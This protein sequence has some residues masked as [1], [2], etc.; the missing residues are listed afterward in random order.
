MTFF[1]PAVCQV[2]Y[3]KAPYNLHYYQHWI[4]L[5]W[6]TIFMVIYTAG[7]TFSVQEIC[8]ISYKIWKDS[9]GKIV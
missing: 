7:F 5:N 4:M 3:H 9:A 2:I 6:T 8:E 1:E